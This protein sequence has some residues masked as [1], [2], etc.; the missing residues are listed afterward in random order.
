MGAVICAMPDT[1]FL[2]G[3]DDDLRL[4]DQVSRDA[5]APDFLRMAIRGAYRDRIA[6]V[7]PFGTEAAVV[8]H[9]IA[10]IDRNTPVI[11]LDTLKQRPETLRYRDMLIARLGLRDVRK[12]A[13][14]ERALHGFEAW[15]DGGMRARDDARTASPLVE[16]ADGR[17]KL[18]PLAAWSKG[19]IEAY[20]IGNDLPRHPLE[21]GRPISV[22]A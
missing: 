10:G 15:I 13:P 14:L 1:N 21:A 16:I 5:S 8:L 22:A 11:F 19:D 12:E 7:S 4:L 9:M 17:L 2:A 20:L 6:V 18:N 3:I